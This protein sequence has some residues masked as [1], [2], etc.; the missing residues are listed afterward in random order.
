MLKNEVLSGHG[1][2]RKYLY[3]IARKG[4]SDERQHCGG[5]FEDTSQHTQETCPAWAA[6]R[7]ALVAAAL[8]VTSR[9]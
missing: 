9:C 4:P 3:I 2:F 7:A 6:E 8:M 5:R 1:C